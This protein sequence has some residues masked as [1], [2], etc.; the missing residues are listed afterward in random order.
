MEKFS[1]TV[2]MFPKSIFGS[3]PLHQIFIGVRQMN[4]KN[5]KDTQQPKTKNETFLQWYERDRRHS[6]LTFSKVAVAVLLLIAC[7]VGFQEWAIAQIGDDASKYNEKTYDELKAVIEANVTNVAIDEKNIR[8]SVDHYNISWSKGDST[9]F[10]CDKVDGFFT[11]EARVSLD[12]DPETGDYKITGSERNY[13]SV[14]E[15]L[16]HYWFVFRLMSYG[17]GIGTFLVIM[18][19]W[20]GTLRLTAFVLKKNKEKKEK[21]AEADTGKTPEGIRV[22]GEE[23]E[24]S[25]GTDLLSGPQCISSQV[26]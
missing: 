10:T 14:G 18:L 5:R 11:A 8:E 16:D 24:G 9:I 26:S 20:N 22:V 15:Y 23:P 2:F 4:K 12:I 19:G 13:H 3:S 25:T 1:I 17:L 6:K 7:V 21:K